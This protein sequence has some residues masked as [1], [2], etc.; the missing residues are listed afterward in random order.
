MQNMSKTKKIIL[1]M[2]MLE[3]PYTGLGQYSIYL[4]QY[5]LDNN[6][7]NHA[8]DF[9][10]YPT[11]EQF[12][13]T[14]KTTYK[15]QEITYLLRKL[16][17]KGFHFIFKKYDIW[18][19]LSQQTRFFPYHTNTPVIYTIHD[20]NFLK[21]ESQEI[22][23]AKLRQIQKQIDRATCIT[24]I[25]NYV[26]QDIA[27]NF[28]LKSKKIEVIYNGAEVKTFQNVPK[29]NFI[30][31]DSPFIFSI[32]A[33][34]YKKNFHS[35]VTMMRHLPHLKLVLAG[36]K[37]QPYTAIIEQEIT[38][39]SLQNQVILAGEVNDQEKYWLYKNCCAFAFPSLLEGF[40]LPI[41]EALSFGKP[42]F[43]SNLTSLPEIGGTEVTYWEHFEPSYM[44][45]I[46]IK[47]MNNI[48]KD[49]TY[50]Q[51]AIARATQFSWQK[52]GK[53]YYDLYDKVLA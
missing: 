8:Y 40:G 37:E 35:L 52:A 46:F 50:T 9:L 47:T 20:L 43:S 36:K 29:P 21:E 3:R 39:Y 30:T 19:V 6:E 2:T 48:E 18:H 41:I 4:A 22:I 51:R 13:N 49:A 53:Q 15:A 24:T 1:D 33:L 5:L 27:K 16:H 12:F 34:T 45:D 44:A 17:K 42:T 28:D 7:A 32:G 38:K 26:A 23:Y 10:M 14:Q 31:D 11:E 25:S